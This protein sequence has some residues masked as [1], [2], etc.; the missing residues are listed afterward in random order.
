LAEKIRKKMESA[1]RGNL[2]GEFSIKFLE[3]D[4]NH[5]EVTFEKEIYKATL[6]NLPCITESYK[7]FDKENFFKTGDV[8]QVLL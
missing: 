3:D 6:V 2:G 1:K 7:T 8:S 5:A 4:L